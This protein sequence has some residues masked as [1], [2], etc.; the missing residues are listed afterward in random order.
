MGLLIAWK[1]CQVMFKDILNRKLRLNLKRIQEV[2][3]KRVVA[4]VSQTDH[5]A[6]YL[7]IRVYLMLEW[8]S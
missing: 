1:K 4:Q 5:F 2:Q 6:L 3:D 8:D 7:K